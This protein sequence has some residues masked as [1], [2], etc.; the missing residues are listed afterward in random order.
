VYKSVVSG[1]TN[2]TRARKLS[3][4]SPFKFAVKA[5]LIHTNL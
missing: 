5:I 4:S 1:H 2:Q 3:I